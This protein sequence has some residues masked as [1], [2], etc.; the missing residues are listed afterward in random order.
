MSDDP[1]YPEPTQEERDLQVAQRKH[2]EEMGEKIRASERVQNMLAPFFFEELGYE[3][4]F[5]IRDPATGELID[6][7]LPEGELIGLTKPVDPAE[8]EREKLRGQIETGMLERSA[9][10]LKGELPINPALQADLERGELL[11]RRTLAAQLGPDWET[12]T[13][14]MEALSRMQ[15]LHLDVKEGARRGDLTLAEQLSIGREQAQIGSKGFD[16]AQILGAG[17]RGL[18]LAS[19]YGQAAG[20]YGMPIGQLAQNRAG[21][22]QAG[23]AGL[24]AQTQ[25]LGSITQAAGNIGGLGLYGYMRPDPK[26]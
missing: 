6:P 13:P 22:F 5:N 24:Q 3:P 23:L 14:G 19:A 18:P 15:K 20:A 9:A 21:K 17:N 25:L 7:S 16:L 11:T 10:A 26:A 1:D 4:R 12:S 2:L 8:E